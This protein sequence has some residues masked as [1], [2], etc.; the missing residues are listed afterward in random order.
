MNFKG[1]CK[2]FLRGAIRVKREVMKTLPGG[3]RRVLTLR[4]SLCSLAGSGASHLSKGTRNGRRGERLT[5]RAS[6]V[7]GPGK[8]GG[9]L[10]EM[11]GVRQRRKK[12]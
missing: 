11:G 5:L 12:V 4:K 1:N 6:R 7:W 10:V 8:F 2:I 9:A 3:G